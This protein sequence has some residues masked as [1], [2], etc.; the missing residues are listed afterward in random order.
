MPTLLKCA[1]FKSSSEAHCSTAVV[2]PDYAPQKV[3]WND[4]QSSFAV[5]DPHSARNT[6]QGESLPNRG[7]S[8]PLSVR[9]ALSN[10][11]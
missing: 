3:P 1:A 4:Q 6:G 5:D 2:M 7:A 8:V 9:L 11:L 10:S